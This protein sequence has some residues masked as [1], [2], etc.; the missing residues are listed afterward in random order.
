MFSKSSYWYVYIGKRYYITFLLI[1][2]LWAE[3]ESH[4]SGLKFPS[5]SNW[6]T[7][8]LTGSMDHYPLFSCRWDE[9]TL[10]SYSSSLCLQE[11]SWEFWE[12][13]TR[14]ERLLGRWM[15]ELWSSLGIRGF[16]VFFYVFFVPSWGK[17]RSR[18]DGGW[19]AERLFLAR[20][21]ACPCTKGHICIHQMDTFPPRWT[22]LQSFLKSLKDWV[23]IEFPHRIEPFILVVREYSEN[24]LSVSVS[25]N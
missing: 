12:F 13:H 24:N 9:T 14:I 22:D 23:S 17:G 20:Q 11:I 3:N 10:A 25:S 15:R 16:F 18:K 19:L 1:I 8:F 2:L 7:L 21:K 5:L 4:F 6:L